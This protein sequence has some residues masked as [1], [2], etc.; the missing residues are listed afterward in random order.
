MAIHLAMG[1]SAT[2]VCAALCLAL[3]CAVAR[4]E[5][6]SERIRRLE[7][8]LAA[9][10]RLIEQLAA[11][12]A[13]L[14]RGAAS[15]T[16]AKGAA[17]LA[18]SAAASAA[19]PP[20]PAKAIA[21][22][23]DSVKQISEGL[24]RRDAESG[25]PLHG[26]ADVSAGWSSARDPQRL[27][28]FNAGSL[29]IYLTP[30]IGYRA[31]ALVEVVFESLPGG[32]QEVDP[33]RLQIGYTVNDAMTVWMGRFH[34]PMGQW[35]TLFHHGANLQTGISRPR[36]IDFE[37]KG[38]LLP[39]HTVG[40]W[41][42]GKVRLGGSQL[43]YDGYVGNGPSIRDRGLHVNTFTD[44]NGS[45]LYG[46]NLGYQPQTMFG[47]LTVGLHGMATRVNAYS[48]SGVERDS[49]RLRMAGTYL[50]YD[51]NDW[52]VLAEVYWL[53]NREAGSSERRSSSLWF[54]QVARALGLWTPFVR[55]ER[56]H[57]DPIDPYFANQ[58]TGRSYRRASAGLRYE[59]HPRAALKVEFSDTRDSAA[60]LVDG[61]GLQQ[62]F[63]AARYR[64]TAIEY[65]I[66]F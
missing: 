45:K 56:V 3:T 28:G 32:V 22:L 2:I 29:D 53:A 37:D 35:N 20:D 55:L 63:E 39:T 18:P 40:L 44:D 48:T 33:E 30:Q 15:G 36:F 13:E 19:V 17:A 14:E 12:V 11:R 46:F 65:S 24:G 23:Q 59:L 52:D 41:A 1:R 62:P 51:A 26:F 58:S 4:A 7:E 49:T 42:N 60:S 25:L 16:A 57:L 54:V 8:R 31:K 6:D 64:R 38:G 66:A 34:T 47:G 50:G 5:T 43:A 61:D 9:N 10:Q 21:S 27:R